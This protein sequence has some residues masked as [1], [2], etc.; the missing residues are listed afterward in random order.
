[1]L[2]TNKG[3][4]AIA[5]SDCGTFAKPFAEAIENI[6]HRQTEG[7]QAM[8]ANRL[9]AMRCGMLP[10]VLPVMTSHSCQCLTKAPETRPRALSILHTPDPRLAIYR[11]MKQKSTAGSPSFWMGQKPR[12]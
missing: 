4:M 2:R 11:K 7:V 10:H 5:T 9:P 12:G 3:V 6:D 1:M 8:G